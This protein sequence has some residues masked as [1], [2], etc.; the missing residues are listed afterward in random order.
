MRT[1][2]NGAARG[3][4]ALTTWLAIVAAT[5]ACASAPGTGSATGTP[6]A[7]PAAG[8]ATALP[9]ADRCAGL[10]AAAGAQLG[11]GVV[12]ASAVLR[13]ASGPTPPPPGSPPWAAPA[14]ATPE[15]CEVL[16]RAHERVGADGQRYAI[17]FHLRLPTRW[18]GRF[19]FQGGGGTDGDVG[20]AIGTVTAGAPTALDR[21]FA[22]V[23]TDAG[24]DNRTNRDPARQGQVAFG[25]DYQ[26]RVDYAERSVE[27]VARTGKALV[28]AFYGRAPERSYFFGCSNGGRQ[29]M[30]LAQRFPELFDG[31]V[32][33]APAF[34]VPRAA[35][36]EAWDT[37]AFAALARR[38]GLVDSADTPLLNR[39]FSDGD[40]ALVARAVVAA[41]DDADGLA[42]GIIG[43]FVACTTARVAPRLAAVTCAGA[44]TDACVTAD[45]V[46]TLKRVHAGP[47]N[48][49]G[50][51]LYADWAWDAGIGAAGWRAWKL[52]SYD[53]RGLPFP[54]NVFLGSP[55]LSAL[56]VTPPEPVPD[57]PR[58]NLRYQLGF[59]MDAD[60]PKIHARTPEFPRSSWE[61]IAAKATDLS[62]FRRRGGKLIV[63]HGVSDPVFSIHDTRRWWEA[64]NA[65]S[66]GRAADFA[67]LFAVPGMNHCGGGPA[68]DRYDCLAAIVDWV[69]RG[70]APARLLAT[71]GAATPWPDRTRPLC[72]YPQVARYAGTGS[73]E[74]A[75][76]FA[77][78]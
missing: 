46:E 5:A 15:H 11:A 59:S 74:D 48:A 77:C 71:A 61:L 47:T 78:R 54:I 73:I 67:R 70:V 2:P 43:D 35:I 56:F 40:L 26:A 21:G 27:V 4:A 31:I 37:Q 23:S 29:G 25:F 42:D 33:S 51:A 52:G 69:E 19:L 66:G 30:I 41:C 1:L 64:V 53:G 58:A 57:D 55:A 72:P 75:A 39:T 9:A 18:N 62:A 22:V 49:K 12:V 50:E 60:A 16:G 10:A 13:A 63:P 34:D 32:A 65:A 38:A 68:T 6:A 36:A 20:D 7:V 44:K 8:A 45:Q 28:A 3:R 24:H 14:P 76:S 17:G